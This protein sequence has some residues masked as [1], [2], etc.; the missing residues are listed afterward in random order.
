MKRWVSLPAVVA[1]ALAA[2]AQAGQVTVGQ[3]VPLSGL[4]ANQGRAYSAGMQLCFSLTNKAGGVNGNTFTLVRKD[5]GGKPQET[6]AVT[7]QLLAESRPTVL[8]GYFGNKNID[9]LVGSGILETE[10]ISLVGYR[11]SDVRADAPHLYSVRAGLRDE[12]KKFAEHVSTIG[13]TRL[14]LVYEESPNAPA[15]LAAME[16]AAAQAKAQVVAKASSARMGEAIATMQTGNPQAILI[17]AGGA[18]TAGFI[19]QYRGAGRNGQLFAQS[20]AD[21]EQ[22]S[23]RLGDEQMQG[24]AIVQVTPSPYQ[25]R[26]R[27]A[28]EFTDAISAA[29][30]V[31]VPVS[32]TMMEGF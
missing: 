15:L 11:V 22:L 30:G 18:A 14:G 3:A 24:V 23:K 26:T 9:G 1:F 19:E 16:E 12:V 13:M 7:R 2:A 10:K 29:N 5:D 31:E 6:L 27:L 25:I 32:Y 21:I 8:A 28:K 20:G 17:V 4:D